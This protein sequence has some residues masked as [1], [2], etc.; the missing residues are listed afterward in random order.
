MVVRKPEIR[1]FF[2]STE[3]ISQRSLNF[4]RKVNLI[5]ALALGISGSCKEKT[6]A[7]TLEKHSD[8]HISGHDQ[9]FL[10][11]VVFHKFNSFF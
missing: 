10:G 7:N 5:N 6:E 2:H 1:G 8:D 4:K 9:N 11:K 3:H